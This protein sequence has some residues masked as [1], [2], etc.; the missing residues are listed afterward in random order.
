MPEPQSPRLK[1]LL[2]YWQARRDAALPSA[3]DFTAKALG[4]LGTGSFLCAVVD[5]GRDFCLLSAGDSLTRVVPTATNGTM[6]SQHASPAVS[7]LQRLLGMVVLRGEPVC[8]AFS[9][10]R[11]GNEHIYVELLAAPLGAGSSVSAI[12][13]GIALRSPSGGWDD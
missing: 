1:R 12:F 4:Q 3:E 9:L 5:G 8:G 11:I 13:G 2:D 6:L 7:R 10:G